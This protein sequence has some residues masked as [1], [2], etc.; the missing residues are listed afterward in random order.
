MSLHMLRHVSRVTATVLRSLQTRRPSAEIEYAASCCV[1]RSWGTAPTSGVLNL[2]RRAYHLH[3]FNLRSDVGAQNYGELDEH[4]DSGAAH[5]AARGWQIV[6]E[7]ESDWKSHAAA[8]ANSVGFIKSRMQWGNAMARLKGL[9]AELERSN[10]WD[11][12]VAAAKC[13]RERGSLVAKVQSL[14]EIEAQLVEQVE[15]AELAHEDNDSQ[16]QAVGGDECLGTH[17]EDLQGN[18]NCLTS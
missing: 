7:K 5:V 13:L 14:R 15:M 8:V 6:E 16:M 18:G 3:P 2:S 12:P 10:I 1:N 11:D 17:S 9:E 4:G